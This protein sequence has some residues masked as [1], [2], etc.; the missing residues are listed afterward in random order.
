[1]ETVY[2]TFQKEQRVLNLIRLDLDACKSAVKKAP[3]GEKLQQVK[4]S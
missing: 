3:P 4:K 1:M 2:I